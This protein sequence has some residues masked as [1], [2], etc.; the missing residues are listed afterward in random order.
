MIAHLRFRPLQSASG[1]PR[2]G[3]LP[4]PLPPT[5]NVLGGGDFLTWGG[6]DSNQRPTDYESE[7]GVAALYGCLAFPPLIATFGRLD[8]FGVCGCLRVLPCHPLATPGASIQRA[9]A[10]APAQRWEWSPA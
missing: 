3:T 6:L 10:L 4:L 7:A 5:K 2:A 8:R 1:V 9:G